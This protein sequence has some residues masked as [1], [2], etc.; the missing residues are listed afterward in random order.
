MTIGQAGPADLARAI[1]GA[2]RTAGATTPAVRGADWRLGIVTAVNVSAGTVDIGQIRARR[3]ESYQA[4]AVGDQI[5]IT[6]NSAGNWLAWDRTSAGTDTS[7]ITPTLGTGYTQGNSSTTG[8]NNGPI[9]YRKFVDRGTTYME[10]DGGAN[11]STG[12]Q[13][14]NILSAALPATYRPTCRASFVIA[15]NATNITGVS[16]STS[17]VHSLKL[18]FNQDG[19]IPLISAAA[20][21]EETSWFSLKGIRYPLD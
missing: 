17:V 7:W 13:V 19:T 3:M 10:W 14:T 20:G 6:Q 16:G 21:N 15:R 4:P 2:A 11:R 18:D 1:T 8:N 12:A 9:R 5:V